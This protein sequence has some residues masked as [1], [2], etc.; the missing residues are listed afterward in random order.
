MIW[1]MEIPGWHPAP[2]NKLMRHWAVAKRLKAHDAKIIGTAL[3]AYQVPET[4]YPRKVRMLVVLPP[5][6]RA[7]DPDS[8]WKSTLDVLVNAGAL[9]NDSQHYVRIDEPRFARGRELVTY[10]TLEDV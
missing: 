7:P 4:K 8:L 10:L 3:V 2:L 5:G 1:T 9:F 6:K